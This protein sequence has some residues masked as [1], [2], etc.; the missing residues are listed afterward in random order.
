MSNTPKNA[1]FITA[2]SNT[3]LWGNNYWDKGRIFPYPIFG[4]VQI[5]IIQL[6]WMNFDWHP[7]KKPYE[8]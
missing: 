2:F 5:N 8:I 7:A 4:K 6:P 1:F 3:N